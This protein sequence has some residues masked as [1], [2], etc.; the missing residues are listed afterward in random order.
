MRLKNLLSFSML[1]GALVLVLLVAGCSDDDPVAPEPCQEFP[2]IIP[3]DVYLRYQ[4]EVDGLEGVTEIGGSLLIRG[5]DIHDLTPLENLG[6]LGRDLRIEQNPRLKSLAPLAGLVD[7]I[8]SLTITRNDSLISLSGLQN[9]TV[10]NVFT[11]QGSALLED[12]NDGPDLSL[13]ERMYLE[14]PE[15]VWDFS[16]LGS[17]DNAYVLDLGGYQGQRVLDHFNELPRLRSLNLMEV[18]GFSDLSCL[19]DYHT[20]E[21]L[22]L[23]RVEG[24][25]EIGPL[26]G[27]PHLARLDVV[28]CEALATLGDL[29]DLPTLQSLNLSSLPA[30][31]SLEGFGNLDLLE[32]L[33]I[34]DCPEIL[35]LSGIPELPRLVSLQVLSMAGLE[36]LSGP[37]GLPSLE[38]L[39]LSSCTALESLTGLPQLPALM[40]LSLQGLPGLDDFS[41]LPELPSLETFSVQRAHGLTS[42]NGLPALPALSSFGIER[43]NGLTDLQGFPALPA[44]AEISFGGLDGLTSL[45]GLGQLTDCFNLSIQG[46]EGLESLTGLENLT[47]VTGALRL[48]YNEALSSIAQLVGLQ[49]VLNVN[50]Y[51]NPVLDQCQVTDQVLTW[52]VLGSI[53][54]GDNGPCE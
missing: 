12:L 28:Q 42:L 52:D 22:S 27:L 26:N 46:C 1:L 48:T 17:A 35:D 54:I 20:L 18:T 4:E 21:V 2:G 14:F 31:T 51:S 29:G 47:N 53:V 39:N 13:T 32:F 15:G 41:G 44:E 45:A 16:G 5:A 43:S 50:I 10:E 49:S 33:T 11:F 30:L 19:D 34:R 23:G 36:S 25:T 37:P 24:L 7:T 8:P 40:V 9:L 6:K 3:G 38:N